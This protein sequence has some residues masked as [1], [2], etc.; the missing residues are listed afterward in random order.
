MERNDWVL[1]IALGFIISRN[2]IVLSAERL[3]A[4]V[5]CT[6]LQVMKSKGWED[7]WETRRSSMEQTR[8]Q[9]PRGTWR[10]SP[11]LKLGEGGGVR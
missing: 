11:P 9:A 8:L 2:L 6:G 5:E 10:W 3:L 7:V 4:E 1:S